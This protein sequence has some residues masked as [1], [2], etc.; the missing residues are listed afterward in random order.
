MTS[1]RQPKITGPKQ[2]RSTIR[3]GYFYP[4]VWKN[5][6]HRGLS[7]GAHVVL[8]ESNIC[9]PITPRQFFLTL[10]LTLKASHDFKGP[11]LDIL[12]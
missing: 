11:G 2:L 10:S 12:P 5:K 6:T 7:I 1:E 3:N 4:C 8:I 9:V